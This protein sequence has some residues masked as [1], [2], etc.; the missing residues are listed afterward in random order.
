MKRYFIIFTIIAILLQG[1]I[2]TGA[3]LASVD[4]FSRAI[5]ELNERKTEWDL[6]DDPNDVGQMRKVADA[7]ENVFLYADS[8][9]DADMEVL[10]SS[11]FVPAVSQWKEQWKG[12]K[13]AQ[14][15]KELRFKQLEVFATDALLRYT[16]DLMDYYIRAR[17]ELEAARVLKK[18]P[19]M[20]KQLA[21]KFAEAQESKK[22][23]MERQTNLVA[24]EYFNAYNDQ[25]LE[26]E[27]YAKKI[28]LASRYE[29]V[30]KLIVVAIDRSSKPDGKGLKNFMSGNYK[31]FMEDHKLPY[32]DQIQ[33]AFDRPQMRILKKIV[34]IVFDGK[35][36]DF[37]I[38]ESWFLLYT[39]IDL[40][41]RDYIARQA[42]DLL[43]GWIG[44]DTPLN[45]GAVPMATVLYQMIVEQYPQQTQTTTDIL[46]AD[47]QRTLGLD[48]A[49]I[50]PATFASSYLFLKNAEVYKFYPLIATAAVGTVM[51]IVQLGVAGFVA[52]GLAWGTPIDETVYERF[53]MS[54]SILWQAL[55]LPLA[56]GTVS[57][58][59][60]LTGKSLMSAAVRLRGY[61][62]VRFAVFG[63][64]ALGRI[65]KDR[66]RAGSLILGREAKTVLNPKNLSDTAL[67]VAVDKASSAVGMMDQQRRWFAA[68][69]YGDI[70]LKLPT[71]F[72]AGI[73]L[74]RGYKKAFFDAIVERVQMISVVAKASAGSSIE[75]ATAFSG[76]SLRLFFESGIGDV[77][78][79]LLAV[80]TR[81]SRQT[82]AREIAE[83]LVATMK[84]MKA[85][86]P[87]GKIILGNAEHNIEEVTVQGLAQDLINGG[88]QTIR[89]AT[90][91]LLK[92]GDDIKEVPVNVHVHVGYR[93]YKNARVFSL[94][95]G[96]TQRVAGGEVDLAFVSSKEQISSQAEENLMK[97]MKRGLD[98]DLRGFGNDVIEQKLKNT[99]D[100]AVD[101]F[102]KGNKGKFMD[103]LLRYAQ[104]NN[105][106]ELLIKLRPITDSDLFRAKEML[107]GIRGSAEDILQG[108]A[109][110]S[111]AFQETLVRDLERMV[112]NPRYSGAGESLRTALSALKANP[113][114]WAV[115]GNTLGQWLDANIAPPAQ[116]ILT[117]IQR[118]GLIK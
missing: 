20:L 17:Q 76:S 102:E 101:N 65:A 52:E 88:D 82:A 100:D 31:T 24:D 38:V 8:I 18:N 40:D 54:G 91:T 81:G 11:G 80:A 84:A 48:H 4:E 10:M 112:Q 39:A 26:E 25:L 19:A 3:V 64:R 113:P 61:A 96:A 74:L 14:V 75:T 95:G 66:L 104:D 7:V 22:P 33:S 92:V 15:G 49:A 58:I 37:K 1:V 29:N 106:E 23:A 107:E 13:M 34:D 68:M 36:E 72:I 87:G 118:R 109:G 5:K 28:A 78:V 105:D 71:Q 86:F 63:E 51:S 103:R 70:V 21:F 30:M 59:K 69:R 62:A 41:S 57:F 89:I 67:G 108:G 9:S 43:H 45:I 99:L 16:R 85:K 117:F 98:A 60:S 55:K 32:N 27:V 50:H 6:L 79:T 83:Q 56:V 12:K 94:S 35:K 115:A 111:R 114:N 53:G 73:K 110:G 42:A 47:I 90:K 116:E 97:T 2:P 77:D 46:I 44:H 93:P